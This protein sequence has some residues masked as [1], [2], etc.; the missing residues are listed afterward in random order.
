[1]TSGDRT[2]R[3]DG[4]STTYKYI[5]LVRCKGG[6]PAW[7]DED[8]DK[9]VVAGKQPETWMPRVIVETEDGKDVIGVCYKREELVELPKR[10][11]AEDAMEWAQEHQPGA[12][13]DFYPDEP[14]VSA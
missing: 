13:A 4:G 5:S 1:M 10:M 3:C 2:L 8:G 12:L 6:N 11:T 14:E 9:S 7:D